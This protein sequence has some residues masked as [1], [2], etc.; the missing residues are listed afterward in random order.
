MSLYSESPYA[1]M[2]EAPRR[3]IIRQELITYE[4]KDGQMRRVTTVRDFY[5]DE[6]DY[7]DTQNITILT[8]R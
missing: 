8:P 6:L 7:I 2:L 1:V 4:N 5:G 3:G